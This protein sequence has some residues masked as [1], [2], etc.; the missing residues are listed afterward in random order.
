MKFK[1]KDKNI[2]VNPATLRQIRELENSTGNIAEITEK[3]PFET[4]IKVMTVILESNPQE[5]G[6]T[7]EWILDNCSMEEFPTLNEVTAHF[8]GVKSVE[9]D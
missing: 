5:E 2:V 3:A 6:M 1:I 4:I 7:I 9:T 8:L